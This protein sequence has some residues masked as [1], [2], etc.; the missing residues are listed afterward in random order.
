V[1]AAVL[2]AFLASYAGAWLAARRR[3]RDVAEAIGD[4]T[5]GTL[6]L[7][8]RTATLVRG[9]LVPAP[10]PFQAFSGELRLRTPFA[11]LPPPAGQTLLFTGQ[12]GVRPS[13]EIVWHRGRVPERA[14]GRGPDTALWVARK[15]DFVAGDFALR[16]ANTSALE[17]AFFDLQARFGDSLR[18]VTLLAD[19]QPQLEVELSAAALAPSELPA[20][21]TTL[22]GLARAALRA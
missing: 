15:L 3:T 16:G 6:R 14:L 17:H 20:L 21:V 2:L 5:R 1:I 13:A 19:A 7:T 8:R 9:D 18:R 4:S 22:R 12:L 10:D 11:V